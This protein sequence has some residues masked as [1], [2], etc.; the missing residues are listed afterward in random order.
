MIHDSA[1]FV[2]LKIV[3]VFFSKPEL[4]ALTPQDIDFKKQT[5]TISKSLSEISGHFEL[6][7]PKS[8]KVRVLPLLNILEK[9]LKSVCLA[10]IEGE[11]I[12]KSP[13]G[14]YL[15]HSN[16]MKRIFTP[17]LKNANIPVITLHELRDTAISQAI[18]TGADVLAISRIAGNSNPSITLNV[19]G[20]LLKDSMGSI[21][22]ALDESYADMRSDIYVTNEE[23]QSA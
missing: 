22:R 19:Y 9:A 20:Y 1:Y 11:S 23:L 13:K 12:F 16:F 15:R 3:G 21:R 4:V 14:G 6:V 17:A 10:T 2:I 5:I 8:G 7:T 18:A